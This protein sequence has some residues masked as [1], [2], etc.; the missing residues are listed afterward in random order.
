[1]CSTLGKFGAHP[2]TLEYVKMFLVS[3]ELTH[4]EHLVLNLSETFYLDISTIVFVNYSLF[5]IV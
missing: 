5:E 4:V 1:M 2:Q 3:L